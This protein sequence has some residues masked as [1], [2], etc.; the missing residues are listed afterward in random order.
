M[1]E[2]VKIGHTKS[3]KGFSLTD[4]AYDRIMKQSERLFYVID[5]MRN[6]LLDGQ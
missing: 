1:A 2:T 4:Y 6:L 5:F 3:K